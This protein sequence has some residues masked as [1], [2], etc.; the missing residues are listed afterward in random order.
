MLSTQI[1]R[2]QPTE[3]SINC[4]A[5]YIRFNLDMMFRIEVVENWSFDKRLSQFD[6]R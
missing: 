1:V 5:W 4:I 6:K 3:D 2:S